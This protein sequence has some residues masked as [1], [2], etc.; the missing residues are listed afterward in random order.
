[1]DE[2]I[3]ITFLF[4]RFFFFWIWTEDGFGVQSVRIN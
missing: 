3:Y 2:I 4:F 1:M